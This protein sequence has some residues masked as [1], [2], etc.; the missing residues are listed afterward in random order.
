MGSLV[1][2]VVGGLLAI[3]VA[4]GL[5]Y[6]MQS[7]V[8]RDFK[9]EDSKARKIADIV[10]PD[11]VIET[12]LKEVLPEK[13]EDPEEPPPDLEPIEF[14]SDVDMGVVNNAPTTGVT[15]KLNSS[16]MSSG[17]GEYL[18]IVKVAPIYPRR[19]QTRGISGYCIV[20]YTVTKTGSI[21]DPQAVDCQPSGIFDR[22]SV[23]A[24]TKF[25]YKPRVVDGE[26]IEVAGVQNKF[27]Y[28]LEQ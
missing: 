22:A 5:F 25:K 13:I 27:T 8:D 14:D 9:Q 4:I 1:R 24:A 10:V 3:P 18:P 17:D 11:K 6:I 12:N 15:L 19:A 23:K 2:I 7:L 21:R 28:E 26:P 20:E 16:G